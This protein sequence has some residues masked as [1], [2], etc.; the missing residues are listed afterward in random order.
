MSES[1]ERIY[2]GFNLPS[3]RT[4]KK[5]LIKVEN[6]TFTPA[7]ANQLALFAPTPR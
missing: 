2:I 7:Q 6:I 5:D 1:G 3:R 4:G